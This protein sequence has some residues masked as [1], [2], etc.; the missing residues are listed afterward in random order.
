MPG[1]RRSSALWQDQVAV[2][3]HPGASLVP[4]EH[5]MPLRVRDPVN[6]VDRSA[7]KILIR[8]ISAG[9][10][11]DGWASTSQPEFP[12]VALECANQPGTRVQEASGPVTAVSADISAGLRP[13]GAGGMKSTTSTRP[14]SAR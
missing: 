1:R 11:L 10:Q 9:C 5:P 3:R 8:Q 14:V 4:A 7:I 6:L 2:S 12:E 13:A